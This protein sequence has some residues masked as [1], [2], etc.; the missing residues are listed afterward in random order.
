ML[1]V[2][3]KSSDEVTFVRVTKAE[4]TEGD[5]HQNEFPVRLR[6]AVSVF[7][8]VTALARAIG[9]SDGAVRKWLRGASEPSVSDVRAIAAATGV[10]IQW[11][12]TGEGESRLVAR[13]IR[14]M[15]GT[16]RADASS[17]VDNALLEAIMETLDDELLSRGMQIP[18]T[19]RS[20]IV[21]TLY[22]LFREERSIEREAV[23]RLLK[24]AV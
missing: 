9:R 18:T 16:Y 23:A 4:S 6:Q 19:K 11:L 24:L 3:H 20:A 14:E 8:S 10:S 22:S 2:W 21:V 7:G 12:I 5:I 15:A 17:S 1:S 13:S